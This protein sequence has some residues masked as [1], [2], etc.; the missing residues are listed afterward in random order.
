[1]FELPV[2]HTAIIIRRTSLRSEPVGSLS[3]RTRRI[4]IDLKPD[5]R[6]GARRWLAREQRRGRE[7]AFERREPFATPRSV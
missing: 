4:C 2:P 5:Q 3:H 1:M 7:R 6:R